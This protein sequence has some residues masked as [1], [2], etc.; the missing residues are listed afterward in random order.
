MQVLVHTDN[1]IEGSAKLTS[2]IQ[3]S[4][5]DCLA[6][7]GD[8][9]TRVEVHLADQNSAAKGGGNDLRCA[10]EARLAGLAPIS[11]MNDAA[12]VDQAFCGALDKLVAALE[13]AI[14]RREDPKGRTPYSG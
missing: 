3:E 10:V 1:H 2:F 12:T 5:A 11:V 6:R 14:G 7:Y 13:R 9:V 8:R 4:V